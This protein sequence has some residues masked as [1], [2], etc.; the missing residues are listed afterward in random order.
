[1]MQI[2]KNV[3]VVIIMK[4]TKVVKGIEATIIILKKMKVMMLIIM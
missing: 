3:T 2:K 4:M 1:M